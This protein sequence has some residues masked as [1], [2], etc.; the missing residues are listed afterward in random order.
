MRRTGTVLGVAVAVIAAVLVT[1]MPG[2]AAG[3]APVHAVGVSQP[4]CDP[5]DPALCL[6]PFPDNFFTRPDGSSATGLRLHFTASQMPVNAS[7]TPVNPTD[8]NASDGFSP[9]SNIETVV[10]GVDLAKT[11]AASITDIAKSLDPNAPIVLLD[12]T[13]GELVPYWA[14]LDTWNA[15]PATRSLIVRPARNFGE[16][17]RIVVALR[18]MKDS[19]GNVIPPSPVFEK[20]RDHIAT[21]NPTI[22]DRRVTMRPVF[23]ALRWIGISRKS[24]FLAWDFTVA[25]K[26]GLSG[27]M[28]HMRDDAYAQLGAGVP[29]F[30]VTQVDAN[31]NIDIVK[32]VQGTFD[33][34]LYLT[35]DGAPG[36]RFVLGPDGLP[37]QL[38]TYHAEFR[39]L[40]PQS[41]TDWDG[42]PHP[43]RA[44]VYGHGLLGSTDEI[45]G[46]APFVDWF[47]MVI[48]ATPEI[49]MAEDDVGNVANVINDFSNFG[50][51]PDR[52]QQGMLNT[53]FLARL[54]KDPR[55]FG[56]DHAFQ[57][58]TSGVSAMVHNQVFYNGNSQGGIFGGSAT[59]IS[60]E[61]T[62]AVLGVPGMNYSELL[63]RSVDFDPFLTLVTSS[64]PDARY[65]TLMV[66]LSQILWDRGEPDG[67]AQHMINDPY[68]GTPN[69]TV[70]LV[71]A[72]G[73]HQVANIS[74]ETEARTLGLPV[75]MPAIAPNRSTDV[76]P[77]WDIP[78]YDGSNP[79]GSVL[80]LWDF[81][82]PA[83][84]ITSTPPES[85]QYGNDPHGAAR[86]VPTVLNQVSTFLQPHGTFVDLCG[87]A[88]C[89]G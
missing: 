13:A 67:Y 34:P 35:D 63:P 80:E 70:L 79:S 10:P 36:G 1:A 83:P 77:M 50:S 47:R 4:R 60:K 40:I 42:T 56:S 27:R 57:I 7:G 28:L 64:Y 9:G 89:Q 6:L 58:G 82:T 33:V 19:A 38:G 45:E 5:I 41:T 44:L 86:R 74:T 51:I 48:C 39:C 12:V 88:P 72:F 73:D 23:E 65:H 37:T 53:Q 46:Y 66:A 20:L 15:D 54:L 8:W 11:G 24:L 59:A 81:G 14:E 75:H 21:F 26:R 32:R 61:W 2:L 62:R 17:D 78:A 85:P 87:A 52:L 68:K 22:E 43:A 69:H 71:E 30:H 29:A 84:P 18:N 25:S 55:G 16:G 76:T 31:P 49:G 3:R